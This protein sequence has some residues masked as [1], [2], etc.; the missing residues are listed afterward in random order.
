MTLCR[1]ILLV[2]PGDKHMS[3]IYF[4]ESG[5]TLCDVGNLETKWVRKWH[6]RTI[7]MIFHVIRN[8]YMNITPCDFQ[9]LQSMA[10]LRIS[11]TEKMHWLQQYQYLK[12]R[13]FWCVYVRAKKRPTS[14]TGQNV[15]LI[16]HHQLFIL[17]GSDHQ[18]PNSQKHSKLYQTTCDCD[19][20]LN[21]N[22]KG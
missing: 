17:T 14:S 15:H 12:S 9:R 20:K 8:E 19:H 7:K 22:T 10:D 11:T 18:M 4:G 13:R 3:Q 5:V 16:S 21:I 6:W 1:I 2:C